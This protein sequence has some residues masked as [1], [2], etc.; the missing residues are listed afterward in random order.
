MIPSLPHKQQKEGGG[1]LHP[2]PSPDNNTK[3]ESSI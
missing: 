1:C 2:S 3:S